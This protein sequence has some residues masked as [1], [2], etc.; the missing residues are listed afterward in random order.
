MNKK[1]LVES[2]V[3]KCVYTP[4]RDLPSTYRFRV[5]PSGRR[6]RF[7]IEEYVDDKRVG[8]YDRGAMVTI[9]ES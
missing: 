3:G 1:V 9:I 7:V 6:D 5:R 4:W 8:V 2:L